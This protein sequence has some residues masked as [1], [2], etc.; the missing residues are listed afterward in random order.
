MWGLLAFVALSEADW[1][2]EEIRDIKCAWQPPQG[3][4]SLLNYQGKMHMRWMLKV[5]Q[6]VK[7]PCFHLCGKG[8]PSSLRNMLKS[9]Q[10]KSR[11]QGSCFWLF[12]MC[13]QLFSNLNGHTCHPTVVLKADS[14]FMKS[15]LGPEILLISY[16]LPWST[17]GYCWSSGHTCRHT[18][19]EHPF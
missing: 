15:G 1:S 11:S 9:H 14:D 10:N 3:A 17:H 6:P 8:S 4:L 18:I 2:H 5:I 12:M 7:W 19:L 16:R 13:L